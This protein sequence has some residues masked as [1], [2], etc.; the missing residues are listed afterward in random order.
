MPTGLPP[1][2]TD[3][4]QNFQDNIQTLWQNVANYLQIPSATEYSSSLQSFA[5]DTAQFARSTYTLAKLTFRPL[6]IL[7][8]LLGHYLFQFLKLAGGQTL[9]HG[10]ISAKSGFSQL[11][12]AAKI[13][14]DFQKGLSPKGV[15]IE[16]GIVTVLV[17]VY[18]VRQY[19]RRRKYVERIGRWW[20]RKK[21]GALMKYNNFVTK[22]SQTSLFLAMLLPHVLY[23]VLVGAIK[24]F[25]PSLVTYF[26]TKTY[27]TAFLSLWHP[28]IKTLGML[29]RYAG[30]MRNKKRVTNGTS[31]EASSQG[32]SGKA[33]SSKQT[34]HVRRWLLA[35][36]T[37]RDTPFAKNQKNTKRGGPSGDNET[38]ASKNKESTLESLSEEGAELLKYWVVYTLLCTSFR[39]VYL[40]PIVGRIFSAAGL[41][42]VAAEAPD[43]VAGSSWLSRTGW[44]TFSLSA[45]FMEETSLIFFVWLCLLPTSFTS[46]TSGW[47]SDTMKDRAAVWEKKAK[48]HSNVEYNNRPLDILYTRLA[49]TA[50]SML[51]SSSSLAAR[52]TPRNNGDAAGAEGVLM[53]VI[54]KFQSLLELAV[55]I[56]IM[57]ASTK[58]R[59]VT[60][61]VESTA[62]LPA[63][64]TLVMPGYFTQ[65]GV[66]YVKDVVPAANSA[67]ACNEVVKADDK[68]DDVAR[69]GSAVRYLRYWII[70][71]LLSAL[72]SSFTPLLAWV[73]FSTH[74][75]FL[76]WSFVQLEGTTCGWYDVFE[77]E[78]VAFGL[79]HA[80]DERK[81]AIDIDKTVTVQLFK[82]VASS[83]PSGT[84][85]PAEDRNA[86]MSSRRMASSEIIGERRSSGEEAGI[87]G[88]NDRNSLPQERVS[89]DGEQRSA[90][91]A[92]KGGTMKQVT[93]PEDKTDK[94]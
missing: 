16:V 49:P 57:K 17:G 8:G 87:V 80:V 73:P 30:F 60:A 93:K 74:L 66:M 1:A 33:T 79:M 76:L 75:T 63:S 9:K 18:N 90:G 32:R 72:L 42:S 12:I 38:T 36:E 71:T 41:S 22:V 4:I 92:E 47:N 61:M 53:S 89:G 62:L 81:D 25:V 14:I 5:H 35:A 69:L 86:G 44:F 3:T 20:K 68:S 78:L 52:T 50:T 85:A 45:Q 10:L 88:S 58:E 29:H 56:K 28:F 37:K 48:A 51:D 40:L 39:T 27:A 43:T 2:L 26:A 19:I 31:T 84:S 70:H 13:A 15:A 91:S 54:K 65:F 46:P 55:M 21:R 64:V 11:K 83:L 34:K 6:L 94:D 59:I 24:Y 77:K 23:V 82:K 67:R 7:L